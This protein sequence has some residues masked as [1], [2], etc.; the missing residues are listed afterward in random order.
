MPVL[1]LR[2]FTN[3]CEEEITFLASWVSWARTCAFAC[4]TYHTRNF[5][6]CYNLGPLKCLLVDTTAHQLVGLQSDFGIN[7]FRLTFIVYSYERTLVPKY[8][9]NDDYLRC[10]N[11]EWSCNFFWLS[12]A[13]YISLNIKSGQFQIPKHFKILL[14]PCWMLFWCGSI[15]RLRYIFWIVSVFS[16]LFQ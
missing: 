6:V 4:M 3:L 2:H 13:L 10:K 15:I 5:P 14:L 11:I 16:W 9:L 12:R 1:F 7:S 8:L